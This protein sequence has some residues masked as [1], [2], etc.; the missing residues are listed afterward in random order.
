MARQ[1]SRRTLLRGAGVGAFALGSAA[2]LPLFGTPD[3]RQ[4]PATCTT[5]DLSESDRRL[6]VSNWPEYIDPPEDGYVSTLQDFEA[7]TGITVRYTADVNDNNEF[8]AKVINQLGACQ[9]VDRDMFVLT[10][11]AAARCIQMGWVQPIAAAN[12]PNLHANLID[13]LSGLAWDPEREFSAP[14]QAGLTG[15][16]YNKKLV[17]KPVG[18]FS[19][20]VTRPDLKGRITLLTEMRDTMG[21]FLLMDGADPADFTDAQWQSAIERL[22]EVKS[23]RQVRAFTGNEYVQDLAAGNIAACEAWSGDVL[24]AGDPNIEFVVPEEGLMIWADNML[25]PNKAEHLANAEKWIDFYFRPDV[26][27]KLAAWVNYICP[28]QG[29]QEEMEK[30]DPDLA[31]DPLIFPDD[32]TLALTNSFMA[33]EEFQMREYEGDFADVTGG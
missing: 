10:D 18:S 1:I 17:D 12:V 30:I 32:E 23:A 28:V 8:F 4:D 20:L 25:V 13:S 9:P 15:I 11:W 26:A 31:S 3:R 27:A 6:I 5:A 14:W 24:A 19:E 29:A 22:R 21:F 16:A 2:V 33:L 7:E